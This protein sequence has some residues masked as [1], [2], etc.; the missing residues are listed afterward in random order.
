MQALLLNVRCNLLKDR[1]SDVQHLV[2][3]ITGCV[4]AVM[5]GRLPKK[6]LCSLGLPIRLR[7][8][9]PGAPGINAL[10]TIPWLL[11][12]LTGGKPSFWIWPCRNIHLEQLKWRQ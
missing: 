11:Q 9:R 4:A 3:P 8:C 5:D 12:S 10:V 2:I 7:T 6:V 1:G